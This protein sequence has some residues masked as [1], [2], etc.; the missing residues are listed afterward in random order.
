MSSIYLD[1]NA[2]TPIDP[3]ALDAMLPFLREEFGNPSSAHAL[4]QR[5]HDAVEQARVQVAAL[6]G[7]QADEIVF[8]SGGTEASN[9]AIRGA[10]ARDS[11]RNAIVTTA[12]E[13]PATV[14]CCALL[15]GQGHPIARIR[16]ASDGVVDPEAVAAAINSRTAIV[17]IIHAQ[18]EI[19]T[20]QP[21]AQIAQAARRHGALVHADAA[22]SLG[23]I[24]FTVDGLG[25][26]LLS[27]AG[28][29]VYAP[30]G[31]GAL[32]VRRGLSVASVL[33]G[34]GQESGRR[35]GTENVAGIVALGEACRIAARHLEQG[36]TPMATRTA[37]LLSRLKRLVP[38]IVCV[39]ESAARLPNTLNVLFP[40]VSGRRL[41]QSCPRVLASNGSAC[42]ADS[43]EPSAILIALGIPRHQALGTVRLSLGRSTTAQDVEDAAASLAAAWHQMRTSSPIAAE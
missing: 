16:S 1:H 26:D 14:A 27:I 4:G 41:L 33:R 17:S 10:V 34:A 36:T 40:D 9:I 7:A 24:P 22:Q 42:H 15:E 6:I 11:S 18:N 12:I 31:I 23:K 2:T 37:A 29:K 30:K 35:P 13:H 32:Y 3:G 19:G 8:T 5:A 25:V 20:I 28:H 39:G 38:G 43:E 21:V